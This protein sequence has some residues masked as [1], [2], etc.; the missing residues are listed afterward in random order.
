MLRLP[1]S[2]WQ[3]NILPLLVLPEQVACAA[4]CTQ[5]RPRGVAPLPLPR[6]C[7]VC[8]GVSALL[9]KACTALVGYRVCQECSRL[10]FYQCLKA[11]Q[12]KKK[13]L[14]KDAHLDGLRSYRANSRTAKKNHVFLSRHLL[15]AAHRVHGGPTGFAHVLAQRRARCAR[16][17]VR[18]KRKRQEAEDRE[19]GTISL[20]THLC[21]TS[22]ACL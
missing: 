12:A 4:V 18:R 7:L 5:L 15:E 10:P 2:V 14:L 6:T 3:R 8:L 20:H 21:D 16:A 9:S 19:R 13:F 11:S 1:I 17:A 22:A